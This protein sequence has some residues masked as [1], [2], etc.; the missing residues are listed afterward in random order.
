M[1]CTRHNVLLPYECCF[2]A[3]PTM[4]AADVV[5]RK[6]FL[7]HA[8]QREIYKQV[9][10]IEPG[11]YVPVLRTGAK[12]SL[13]MNCLGYHWSAVTYKYMKIRD[14]D[15]RE[16]APVPDFLQTAAQRAVRETAYWHGPS[17]VPDYDICI[18]NLYDD[19]SGKLGVHADNSE[20]KES[21]TL[22]YPVV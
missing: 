19:H 9:L 22:G 20:T 14:V 10:L 4:S 8:E 7:G 17:A 3:E 5:L 6:C 21:L 13:R 1:S 11:F 18:V 16:V 15:E 12:M 2:P